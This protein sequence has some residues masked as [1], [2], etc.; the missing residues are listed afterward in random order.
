MKYG[1]VFKCEYKPNSNSCAEI[2][3]DSQRKSF[4]MHSVL[5]KIAI[6]VLELNLLTTSKMFLTLG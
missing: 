3:V 1:T 4:L 2:A 6:Y 5:K